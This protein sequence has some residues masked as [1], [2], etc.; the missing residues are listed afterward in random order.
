[1]LSGT[2]LDGR[3][4]I[5]NGVVDMGAY[6]YGF[7]IGIRFSAVDIYW[8]STIGSTYQ[9]Q[10]CV[11]LINGSWTNV[12]SSVTATGTSSYVVDWIRDSGRKFYKVVIP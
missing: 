9:V 10:S 1:M 4:R 11:D 2:D 6:E 8:D 3:Q 12:G 5:Q 7:T